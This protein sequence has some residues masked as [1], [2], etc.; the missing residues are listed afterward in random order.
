M[1]NFFIKS[2][3]LKKIEFKCFIT[4]C[5]VHVFGKFSNLIFLKTK[6]FIQKFYSTFIISLV[7]LPR[8]K[9]GLVSVNN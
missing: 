3:I 4:N 9:T 2:F 7:S 1:S 8:R 5:L 6:H